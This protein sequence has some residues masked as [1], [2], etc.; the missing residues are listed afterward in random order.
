MNNLSED[1][2]LALILDVLRESNLA[3]QTDEQIPLSPDAPL[4]GPGSPLDSLEFVQLIMD[5]EDA[6]SEKGVA[7]SLNDEKAMS[8]RQSPFRDVSSLVAY[9]RELLSTAHDRTG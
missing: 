7:L 5:I 2:I 1:E 4:Y 3:R 8:Q 6:F 9:S